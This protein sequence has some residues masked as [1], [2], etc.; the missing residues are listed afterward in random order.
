MSV[1]KDVEIMHQGVV[2]KFQIKLI[3]AGQQLPPLPQ[4]QTIDALRIVK[5][6]TNTLENNCVA[7]FDLG[8]RQ[9]VG[10][11][12][13]RF[14]KDAV[15]N[16]SFEISLSTDGQNWLGRLTGEQQNQSAVVLSINPFFDAKYVRFILQGRKD[17]SSVE[18]VEIKGKKLS[19]PQAPEPEP[20][21]SEIT[22]AQAEEG[23]TVPTTTLKKTTKPQTTAATTA[24]KKAK[25]K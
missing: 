2:F 7:I 14:V 8:G 22:V 24:T 13:V 9:Q 23:Q 1:V 20:V 4:G 10:E 12:F 25:K 15:P 16:A 19:E 21:K 11:V 18:L 3:A 6:T 17:F 5:T